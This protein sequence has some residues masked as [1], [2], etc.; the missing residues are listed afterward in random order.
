MKAEIAHRV[1]SLHSPHLTSAYT[2]SSSKALALIGFAP[3]SFGVTGVSVSTAQR[4]PSLGP[5]T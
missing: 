1:Y 3:T 4:H 5:I 2:S